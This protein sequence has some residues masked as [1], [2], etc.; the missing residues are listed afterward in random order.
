[1]A[2]TAK[3]LEQDTVLWMKK[4]GSLLVLSLALAIIVVDTTILNVSLGAIIRDLKTDIQSIQ[5]VITIYAL[6]LAA[7]TI[8]GGR[9]GDLFGRKKMFMLGAFIFAIG[10]FIASVSHHVLPLLIGESVVEGLGAALMMPATASLLVANF[11]G[12]DRAIAFGVWGG[13]AAAAAALG[14]ILGGFLTTRYSWRWAFRINVFIAAILI[15]G[16]V[17]VNESRDTAER[18]KLDWGG[19]F[20]SGFGLLALVFG[21]IESETYGWIRAKEIFS[22]IGHQVNLGTISIAV[23]SILIGVM[24]LISFIFY[25]MRIERH[26]RTPLVSMGL[27]RNR[28]FSSGVLTTAV[29]SLGQTGIFFTFPVFFQAVRGLDALH[30]GLALLPMPIGV[31]LF[32]AFSAP[33]AKRFSAKRLIQGGLLLNVIGL[34]TLRQLL[35]PDATI[36]HLAPGFLLYGLGFGLIMPHISNLTLS[37]VAVQQAGEA[38]GVNNTMRQLGATLGSAII[39]AVLLTALAANLSS[40][41]K[42]SALIPAQLKDQLSSTLSHQTSNVEFGGGPHL[43]GGIPTTITKEITV[44]SHNATT[45]ANKTALL[46]S[47]L[48]VLLGIAASSWL[49]NVKNLERNEP[50]MDPTLHHKYRNPDT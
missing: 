32:S 50:A 5:W 31:F 48:F 2:V 22:I 39:G 19:V 45:D 4:W 35:S 28:Q 49:P 46:Y 43:V 20:L 15:L 21:I 13:I 34:L 18:A 47:V 14:P 42:E 12:R 38:S 1:M 23:P 27:F 7:L 25:E 36:W 10:S 44:I 37:A 9:L 41:V 8:T 6:M 17:L 26:G 16:S 29:L 33:L 40:G 30:T 24:F 11:R 3:E